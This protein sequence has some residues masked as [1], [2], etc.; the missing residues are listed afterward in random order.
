MVNKNNLFRKHNLKNKRVSKK[1]G[2]NPKIELNSSQIEETITIREKPDGEKYGVLVSGPQFYNVNHGPFRPIFGTNVKKLNTFGTYGSIKNV[3]AFHPS[4]PF[5][6]TDSSISGAIKI[7]KL[8]GIHEEPTL[9]ITAPKKLWNGVVNSVSFHSDLPIFA[10]A[11]DT[12]NSFL[13]LYYDYENLIKIN[14]QIMKL[15]QEYQRRSDPPEEGSIQKAYF[16]KMDAKLVLCRQRIEEI[17]QNLGTTTIHF[18]ENEL[19]DLWFEIWISKQTKTQSFG[20]NV[21]V[22]IDELEENIVSVNERIRDDF[23]YTY[24]PE[25]GITDI[26]QLFPLTTKKGNNVEL[27]HFNTENY[28][29]TNLQTFN[30]HINTVVGV[31]FHPSS[32]LHLLA[33][34][35]SN[36]QIYVHKFNPQNRLP[37]TNSTQLDISEYYTNLLFHP[38][39]P[40]LLTY[41]DNCIKLW[42]VNDDGSII[43]CYTENINV[44][45]LKRITCVTF[46]PSG[47]KLAVGFETDINFR[48][49]RFT[50]T[51]LGVYK[52]D[53]P[54][55]H[56][57]DRYNNVGIKTL[58]FYPNSNKLVVSTGMANGLIVLNYPTDLSVFTIQGLLYQ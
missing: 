12:D 21:L 23:R 44:D 14:Q 57:T 6:I 51:T 47:E 7:W 9:L 16:D 8:N 29:I 10:V 39:E 45:I 46:H 24:G 1:K 19:S 17:R 43:N 11:H 54:I 3:V 53:Q 28:H 58:Q 38:I 50:N 52:I 22:K 13:S 49:Y 26:T 35:S 40:V 18:R 55:H 37:I 15:I 5:F 34:I 36:K 32:H 27:W 25:Y 4:L 33:S 2:G 41:S 42:F 48:I 30:N 56:T 31:M 20:H